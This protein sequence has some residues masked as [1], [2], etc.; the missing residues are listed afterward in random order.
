MTK[1]KPKYSCTAILGWVHRNTE[2]TCIAGKGIHESRSLRQA[3][4]DKVIMLTCRIQQVC[5]LL[6]H[7]FSIVALLYCAQAEKSSKSFQVKEI[8]T[9]AHWQNPMG[10]QTAVRASVPLPGMPKGLYPSAEGR[11][12]IC[13]ASGLPFAVPLRKQAGVQKKPPNEEHR[14]IFLKNCRN[15]R[16]CSIRFFFKPL[17]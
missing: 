17:C 16:V 1:E 10:R 5:K 9:N 15:E 2:N 8:R 4:P 3:R 12:G 6:P 13:P 11:R 14:R 7:E